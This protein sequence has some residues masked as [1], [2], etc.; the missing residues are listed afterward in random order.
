LPKV[1][2]LTGGGDSSA[3]NAAIEAAT[4]ALEQYG[5]QVT[6]FK[7]GWD[8]LVHNQS[9]PLK[10]EEIA[11]IRQLPGT[12]LGTSRFNPIRQG[13]I[14]EILNNLSDFAGLVVI[15][16]DDTLSVAAELAKSGLP[17]VGIPQTIDNDVWGTER[18]LGFE[19]AVTRIVEAIA[20]LVSTNVSHQKDMLVEVMGRDSGWLAVYGAML[21]GAHEFLIPEEPFSLENLKERIEQL[22]TKN[23]PAMIIVAEGVDLPN[24]KPA[25]IQD[26][27]GNQAFAGVS[28][29]L[30]EEL[31][32]A[33]L[34]KPRTVVLSYLQRGGKPAVSDELLALRM[35]RKA[36]ELIHRSQ[37]GVMVALKQNQLTS[38]PLADV[39][40]RR[41]RVPQEII[42]FA[43]G[44]LVMR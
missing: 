20:E 6:G 39:I 40:G 9:I 26:S 12:Y 4:I 14:E 18:C 29:Q 32:E 42:D 13:K 44:L 43:R 24:R 7:N 8:G 5:F 30:A 19:T 3:I 10:S 11:N 37:G 31:A 36:A 15:G 35:G 41:Q 25:E 22:R 38:I 16:G 2:L 27:F 17:V 33:G 23:Q 21:S 34:S 1:G 28:F